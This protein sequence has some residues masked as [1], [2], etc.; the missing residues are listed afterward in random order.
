MHRL[1]VTFAVLL[2]VVAVSSLSAAQQY[3]VTDLGTLEGVGT[4][5][6]LAVND[7]GQ[8]VGTSET[9]SAYSILQTSPASL[10]ASTIQVW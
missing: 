3:T 9:T 10:M 5:V 2:M 1:R 7:V 8:V 6:A 4:S